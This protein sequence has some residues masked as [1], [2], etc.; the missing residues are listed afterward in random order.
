MRGLATSVGYLGLA[1]GP[2]LLRRLVS[3]PEREATP[4]RS[5]LSVLSYE[6]RGGTGRTSG[7]V[8]GEA[9]WAASSLATVLAVGLILTGLVW[10]MAGK[11]GLIL[12]MLVG[13]LFRTMSE[14]P[15]A[16]MQSKGKLARDNCV[17]AA[18]EW[19]WPLLLVVGPGRVPFFSAFWN[20]GLEEAVG[21]YLLTGFAVLTLR[22]CVA[23]VTSPGLLRPR[24]G[25][26]ASF[27][28]SQLL[29]PAGL[30]LLSQLADFCYAPLNQYLI[31][32]LQDPTDV[33][34]YAPALQI[35]A[36]LLLLTSAVGAVLLP[37]A[38]RALAQGEIAEVRRDYVRGSLAS[39]GVLLV[40]AIP[41]AIGSE[42][43]L[44]HWLGKNVLPSAAHIV[45]MVLVHTVI[46]GTAGIGRA[47]LL[48]AG[49]YRT[50]ALVALAFGVANATGAAIVLKA[51]WGV[52][53]VVWVTIV[54]VSARCLLWM[55]WYTLRM[56]ARLETAG[57]AAMEPNA[58]KPDPV[59]AP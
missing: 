33:A 25:G 32:R 23:V 56:L 31:A 55:P 8:A 9:E 10:V 13:M 46:G 11:N 35:D 14:V 15:G 18:G 4:E 51:G 20:A 2:V 28:G 17:V 1:M 47:V 30:L 3:L 44:R 16:V 34:A 7:I 40:A 38:T 41:V 24:I 37:H 5:G 21:A 49:R 12:G 43:I 19:A 54:T 22:W 59:T 50:Y 45:P 58:P 42:T 53:G 29:A 36:A 48:A 26:A 39:G 52:P 6:R 27:V 57:V